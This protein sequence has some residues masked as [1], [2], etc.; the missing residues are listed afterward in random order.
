M[1]GLPVTIRLLDPP[2]H[3]FLPRGEKEIAELSKEMNISVEKI[4]QKISSLQEFNPM[5]GFR[6]CRLGIVYPE[7]TEMQVTAIIEAA[8]EI[9]KQGLKVLPEIEIPV[10]GLLKEAEHLKA[11]IKNT[12]DKLLSASKAKIDY[13]IGTMIE[14]PRACIIAEELAKE[15]DFFSFGT[16]DLTQTTLGFSR[17]DASKFIPLYIEKGIL[18]RDPF[19]VLD[20]NGVGKLMKQFIENVRKTNPNAEIGICGEHG[21]DPESVE[22]CHELQ[23]NYVSCSPYRVPIARLAAAHAALK[24]KIECTIL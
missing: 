13:K 18:E 3:E 17:D 4:K 19:Q 14:L 11:L 6:G 21:G 7:I 2:L 23:L 1:S 8:I 24:S 20:R 12:S 9:N 10:L 15:L 16:N 22:F 5:L